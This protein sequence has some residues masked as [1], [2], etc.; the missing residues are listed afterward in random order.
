MS[1]FEILLELRM[2]EVVEPYH[3]QSSS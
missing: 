3:V 1:P 2:I